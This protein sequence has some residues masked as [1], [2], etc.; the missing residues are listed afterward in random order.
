M[1]RLVLRIVL[2][3]VAANALS[4]SG[5]LI[6]SLRQC[7][8]NPLFNDALVL[9]VGV[10]MIGVVCVVLKLV[11]AHVYVLCGY[12]FCTLEEE[13]RGRLL[14]PLLHFVNIFMEVYPW[15][16]KALKVNVVKKQSTH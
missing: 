15:N 8:Y 7:S 14:C 12:L 3:I 2:Q 16:K 4:S 5:F 1:P 6:I 9:F 11:N 10:V 13:M